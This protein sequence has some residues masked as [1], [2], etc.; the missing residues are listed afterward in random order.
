MFTLLHCLLQVFPKGCPLLHDVNKALLTISEDGT[1]R[2]LENSMLASE[3]C[4]DNIDDPAGAE[5]TSLSPGSFLVLF[6][7]TG[8]TS[9]TALVIYI[10]PVNYLCHGRRTMWSLMMAVIKRWGSQNRLLTR[11]HNVA[12]ENPSNSPNVS[13]LPTLA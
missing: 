12:A 1:L 2:D 7:L 4:K 10:F 6:I 9:T 3:E 5:T 11:V 13:N 8:G